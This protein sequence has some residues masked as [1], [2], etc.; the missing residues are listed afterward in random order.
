MR[1]RMR[2]RRGVR[3]GERIDLGLRAEGGDV[4]PAL[5]DAGVRIADHGLVRHHREHRGIS[6]GA[7]K[8]TTPVVKAAS[9]L[10]EA[11]TRLQFLQVRVPSQVATGKVLLL[12]L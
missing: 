4:F 11:G 7:K 2:V 3:D 10:S 8:M 6:I 5:R 12:L 1:A 9:E